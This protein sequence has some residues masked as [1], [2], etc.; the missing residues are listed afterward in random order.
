MSDDEYERGRRDEIARVTKVIAAYHGY[1]ARL[2]EFAHADGNRA[3]RVR[4][5]ETEIVAENLLHL[6]TTYLAGIS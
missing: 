5:S 3:Q 2:S 6:A 1:M 4:M